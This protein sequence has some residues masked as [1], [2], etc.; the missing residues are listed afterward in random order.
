MLDVVG[1]VGNDAGDE[2]LAIGQLGGLPDFPFVGVAGV[3]GLDAVGAG[4]DAQDD[5]DNV[6]E[7]DVG[8]VGA[9]PATPAEV[10]ADAVL[11]QALEGVVE[12]IDAQGGEVPV[13][14]DGGGRIGI[15]VLGDDAGSSTWRMKPASTMARYSSRM[16][17]AMA[18][19][20]SS[21]VL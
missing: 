2:V 17:S 13:F 8:G 15:A 4:V 3:G 21:W 6:A 12:G 19:R 14:L 7:G 10:V 9:V 5:V 16:A 11:G 18:V 1:G 20:N